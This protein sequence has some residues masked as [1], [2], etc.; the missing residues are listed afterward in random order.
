M[1][2]ARY[3]SWIMP[4]RNSISTALA[5]WQPCQLLDH[6]P[7]QSGQLLGSGRF[8]VGTSQTPSACWCLSTLAVECWKFDSSPVRGRATR[9]CAGGV[10]GG[11]GTVLV[12]RSLKRSGTYPYSPRR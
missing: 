6:C 3:V 5:E 4:S 10:D 11:H 9:R 12:P 1:L 8:A 2:C 7:E